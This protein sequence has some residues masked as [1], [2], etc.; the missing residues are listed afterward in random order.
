MLSF[1]G[2]KLCTRLHTRFETL[3]PCRP[4]IIQTAGDEDELVTACQEVLR[5]LETGTVSK[6][7]IEQEKTKVQEVW[8]LSLIAYML[9]CPGMGPSLLYASIGC[10]ILQQEPEQGL[11]KLPCFVG[12]SCVSPTSHSLLSP[13]SCRERLLSQSTWYFACGCSCMS[14]LCACWPRIFRC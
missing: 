10:G 1:C 5:G 7:D 6:E 14:I 12:A 8:E 4:D 3:I 9:C 11:Q 13:P 2:A